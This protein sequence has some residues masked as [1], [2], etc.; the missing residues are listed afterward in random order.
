LLGRKFGLIA[1]LLASVSTAQISQSI[2]LTNQS[3]LPLIALL[4]L[5]SAVKYLKKKQFIFLFLLSFLSGFAPTIHSQGFM[6]IPLVFITLVFSGIPNFK[7][8]AIILL[9][10]FLPWLPIFI[11]DS[12]NHFYNTYNLLAYYLH[13]QY[14]ISLDV[15]GRRWLTYLGI[16]WPQAWAHIIGGNAVFGYIIPALLIAFA[17]TN[18]YKKKISKEW[19]LIASAFLVMLIMIRYVRVPLFDSNL[20][21]TNAFVLLLTGW[22]ILNCFKVNRIAGTLFLI[23]ILIFSLNKDITFI[24]DSNN[25]VGFAEKNEMI[26]LKKYPKAKFAIY[27]H[28]FNSP[29]ISQPATLFLDEKNRIDDNG[30]KIGFSTATFS[31]QLKLPLIYSN[32]IRKYY[33]FDISSLTKAQLSLYGWELVNPSAVYYNVEEWYKNKK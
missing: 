9:G 23:A 30:L 32:K 2:N 18:I 14:A 24:L 5:W 3:P 4:A 10:L 25:N 8:I 20:L 28:K 7:K 13:G 16:F 6:L 29:E 19:Y 27:D 17:V 33:I 22:V 11:A 15:L 12:Y 31:A 1:G 21:V 26:L